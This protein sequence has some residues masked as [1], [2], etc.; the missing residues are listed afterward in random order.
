MLW[1]IEIRVRSG[2][3][4]SWDTVEEIVEEEMDRSTELGAVQQ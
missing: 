4:D 1:G 2:T 3:M